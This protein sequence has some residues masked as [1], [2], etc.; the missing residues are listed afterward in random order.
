MGFCEFLEDCCCGI[1]TY[2]PLAL[3]TALTSYG[4]WV[5][6]ILAF[7]QIHDTTPCTFL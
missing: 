3:V 5:L 2:F 6:M 1:A 4:A 7:D